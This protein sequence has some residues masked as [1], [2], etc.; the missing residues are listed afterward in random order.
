MSRLQIIVLA[1]AAL[2]CLAG[3]GPTVTVVNSTK[4]PVRVV[5][6]SSGGTESLSPSPGESSAAEVEEGTYNVSAIADQQ[7]VDYAKATRQYLNDQIANSG[8]LS[9]AQLLAVVQRLKEVATQ[10]QQLGTAGASGSSCSGAVTQD[11]DGL[12][13]ITVGANGKLVL[14]CR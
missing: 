3:C 6:T 12:A 10:M 14:S 7:W 1:L 5:V 11:A 2:C 8:S 13:T 4:I 9:G